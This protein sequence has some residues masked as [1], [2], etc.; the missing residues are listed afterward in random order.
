ML[1]F[2][3]YRG[4]NS[5]GINF[6]DDEARMVICIGVPYPQLS[7]IKV[8][9][10]KD[11]LN[12]KYKM[13]KNK[14]FNGWKWYR[15]EAI[16]AVNQSLGR[17][18]RNKN[19]YGIMICFG[20]EF[21]ERNIKFSKWINDNISNDSF[22]RLKENDKN[23]FKGLDTFLSNLNMKFPKNIINQE[24]NNSNKYEDSLNEIGDYEFSDDNNDINDD[25]SEESWEK[26][27]YNFDEK[28]SNIKESDYSNYGINHI[29]NKRYRESYDSD[30]N[31]D[32]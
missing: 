18:I 6:N 12:Q 28:Y 26:D 4:R 14:N 8:I 5:E 15:E 32:G 13:E 29:G 10:K 23:Y 22:I 30:D 25:D 27:K 7:D 9:L 3:V 2:T 16:N 19:D 1:L 24:I 20:I 11:Y 17:L 31:K 21:S